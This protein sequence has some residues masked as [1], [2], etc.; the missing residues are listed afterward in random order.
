M[1]GEGVFKGE[2]VQVELPLQVAELFRAGVMQA[3]PDEVL[4]LAGP[5]LA[6]IEAD[7][8]D[9]SALGV[10]GGCNDSTHGS[11]VP[12][13][14]QTETEINPPDRLSLAAGQGSP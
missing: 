8:G 13:S 3:D 2:L 9:L 11:T 12:S 10:N 1:P 14:I 7:V 5:L 4:R 6:F